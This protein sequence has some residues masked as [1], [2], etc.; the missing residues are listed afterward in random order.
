MAS[1]QDERLRERRGKHHS[2]RQQTPHRLPAAPT[3]NTQ[4]GATKAETARGGT[5]EE[6]RKHELSTRGCWC[7]CR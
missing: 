7:C 6:R 1:G 3:T 2:N 5:E 4:L